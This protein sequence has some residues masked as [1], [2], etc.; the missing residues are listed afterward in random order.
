MGL[1]AVFLPYPHHKD[2]Q[3][4]KNA[5][6]MADVGAAVVLDE[7][8]TGVAELAD[9]IARFVRDDEARSRAAQAAR[10]LGRPEAVER[11]VDGLD[12]LARGGK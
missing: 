2:R 7:R 9:A 6:P 4:E 5:A 8:E 10:S 1:P 12:E 3:Q 11:I